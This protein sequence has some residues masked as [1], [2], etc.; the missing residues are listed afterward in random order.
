MARM[1]GRE[2]VRR[3]AP[4]PPGDAGHHD[5]GLSPTRSHGAA[6][7]DA[8]GPGSAKSPFLPKRPLSAIAEVLANPQSE[9]TSRQSWSS[10]RRQAIRR[11]RSGLG[12]LWNSWIA[13]KGENP[14]RINRILSILT[15]SGNTPFS[16]SP[17]SAFSSATP[18]AGAGIWIQ[19]LRSSQYKNAQLATCCIPR[20]RASPTVSS[21]PM[22]RERSPSQSGR[23]AAHRMG[24]DEA[25]RPRADRFPVVN[26]INGR[27]RQPGCRRSFASRVVVS[28]LKPCSFRDGRA[29]PSTSAAP[30]RAGDGAIIGVVLVLRPDRPAQSRASGSQPGFGGRP[31]TTPSS[32]RISMA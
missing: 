25:A 30:I 23:P 6:G 4:A 5:V 9:R 26:Q 13:P 28:C 2:L 18:V 14:A 16:A 21:P 20:C 15:A 8:A 19:A 1:N 27:V 7:P 3:L 32:E 29:I 22:R 11:K 10:R 12:C 24:G 17:R 31:P